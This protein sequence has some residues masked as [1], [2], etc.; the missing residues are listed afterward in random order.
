MVDVII[1]LPTIDYIEAEDVYAAVVSAT[2]R[3]LVRTP[4]DALERTLDPGVF[5]RIHRSYIVRMDRVAAMRRRAGSGA[6]LIMQ[7]GAVLP[8][9]RRRRTRV[10]ELFGKRR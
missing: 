10:A 3:Q 7:S 8:V 2:K 5:T 4:L 1:P 9:S 6:E